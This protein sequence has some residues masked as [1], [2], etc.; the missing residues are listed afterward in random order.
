[1]TT[2]PTTPMRRIEARRVARRASKDAALAA[3][4]DGIP[5]EGAQVWKNLR[6]GRQ[7]VWGPALRFIDWSVARGTPYHVVRTALDALIAYADDAFADRVA[8]VV[9]RFTSHRAA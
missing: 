6:T 7:W 9:S 2:R 5:A 3:T 8:R 1:M 4:K